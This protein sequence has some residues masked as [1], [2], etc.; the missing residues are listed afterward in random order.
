M[1]TGR[2]LHSCPGQVQV[3]LPAV[4]SRGSPCSEYS[5]AHLP[6]AVIPLVVGTDFSQTPDE[7]PFLVA[8]QSSALEY[9]LTE[10]WGFV[11]TRVQT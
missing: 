2:H 9:S 3:P 4:A 5:D 1:P 11:V 6:C 8:L 10:L 7:H